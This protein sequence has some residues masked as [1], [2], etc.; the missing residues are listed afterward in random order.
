MLKRIARRMVRAATRPEPPE[1]ATH[2]QSRKIDTIIDVGANTGQFATLMRSE[3]FSGRIVSFEPLSDAFAVLATKC[4]SD[5]GW[6]C[7]N[8][9]LG[10]SEASATLNISANSHSSS[11]LEAT[12][13]A[14]SLEPSIGYVGAQQV[15]VRRL[16]QVLTR[17]LLSG[18]A[19]LKIDTQG[20]ELE[21]LKGAGDLLGDFE[22][23]RLE[24]ALLPSY[25]GQPSSDALIGWLHDRGFGVV[26]IEQGWTDRAGFVQ[27]IDIVF[28]SKR[29]RS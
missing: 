21:V 9:A 15:Q 1:R 26:A 5:Q 25:V 12:D 16:D 28:A 29:G 7:H 11:I 8:L 4:A 22:M 27:E 3:G 19:L 2:M 6:E 14:V 17:D 20:Y 23:I 18:R 10:A 13:H 24:A